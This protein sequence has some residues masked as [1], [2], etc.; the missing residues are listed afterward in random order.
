M[1]YVV[2]DFPLLPTTHTQPGV[3]APEVITV[4]RLGDEKA[5]VLVWHPPKTPEGPQFW[6]WITCLA[7]LCQGC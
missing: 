5:A 2:L 4:S 7:S 3:A 1:F 6:E